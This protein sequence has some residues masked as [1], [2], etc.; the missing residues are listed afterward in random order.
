MHCLHNLFLKMRTVSWKGKPWS[1]T[2]LSCQDPAICERTRGRPAMTY[3]KRFVRTP[4]IPGRTENKPPSCG[5]ACRWSALMVKRAEVTNSV[6][7]FSPPKAQ[8]VGQLQGSS[9]SRSSVPSGAIRTT[10]LPPA[11]RQFQMIAVSVHAGPVRRPRAKSPKK[12][13]RSSRREAAAVQAIAV[14]LVLHRVGGDEAA[15]RGPRHGIGDAET[16]VA[17]EGHVAVG[18]DSVEPSGVARDGE[19]CVVRRRYCSS[20]CPPRTSRPARRRLHSVACR[21]CRARSLRSS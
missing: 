14:E 15:I 20:S 13:R 8:L 18:V 17:E 5:F 21:D 6:S 7:R 1:D 10:Q 19:R 11:T 2:E 3:P 4:R 16:I 12:S 9:T